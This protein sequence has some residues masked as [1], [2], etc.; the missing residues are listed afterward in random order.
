MAAATEGSGYSAHVLYLMMPAFR[1][2]VAGWGQMPPVQE[3]EEEGEREGD[4]RSGG[5]PRQP[6]GRWPQQ[7]RER[8]SPRTDVT[9]VCPLLI[10]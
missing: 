5:R 1:F 8:P 9:S 4:P 3:E 7:R 6:R 2:L 10:G